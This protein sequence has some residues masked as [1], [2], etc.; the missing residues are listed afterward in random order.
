MWEGGQ[1]RGGQ[2]EE[3]VIVIAKTGLVSVPFIYNHLTKG[4][5]K[6]RYDPLGSRFFY[7][8]QR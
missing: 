1:K 3:Q 7:G 5:S 4:S 2:L 6:N 8:L